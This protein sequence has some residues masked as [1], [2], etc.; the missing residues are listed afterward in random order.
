MT[1]LRATNRDRQAEVAGHVRVAG[2]WWERVQGLLGQR[3]LGRGEGLL[4]TPC[5]GVHTCGLRHPIDVAFLSADYR[6]VALYP[7]LTPW[8]ITSVHRAALVALEL[9]AG[10]LAASNTHLGDRFIL[11]PLRDSGRRLLIP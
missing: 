10:T 8:R 7:D 3:P 6:V 11:E 2:R 5:R 4:I 1:R 9:P